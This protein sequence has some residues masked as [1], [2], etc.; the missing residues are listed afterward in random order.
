MKSELFPNMQLSS[1]LFVYTSNDELSSREVSSFQTK[2]NA[3]I[4]SW[5]AHGAKLD[6]SF[7]LIANRVLI[8]V[9]DEKF[10]TATGC[11]IDSMNRYLQDSGYDW[12]SRTLV[13]YNTGVG[14]LDEVWEASNMHEFHSALKRGDLSMDIL[15]I[16][17][18][19]LSLG[20]AREKL[21][22][23]VS[24]SWHKNML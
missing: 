10:Q 4:D 19:V 9:V 7:M 3:F 22:Q 5:K 1:R 23:K 18:T 8:I 15:V 13:L 24:E 2:L 14:G 16:N 11:S 20:E 6:A 12:F 21:V 17:S